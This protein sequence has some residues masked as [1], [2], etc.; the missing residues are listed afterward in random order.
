VSQTGI[1]VPQGEG[2]SLW[3]LDQL[4]TF[5]V[6]QESETVEIAEAPSWPPWFPFARPLAPPRCFTAFLVA[7]AA[8]NC[9]ESLRLATAQLPRD[10]EFPKSGAYLSRAEDGL[11]PRPSTGGR[12]RGVRALYKG[13]R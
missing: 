1:H 7:F 2:K 9:Y 12:P 8:R 4:M 10:R 3:I 13:V 5:K 6:H 11:F